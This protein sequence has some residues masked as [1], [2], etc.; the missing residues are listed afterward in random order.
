M[1]YILDSAKNEV[2][3]SVDLHQLRVYKRIWIRIS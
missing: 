1:Y 2:N 3:I